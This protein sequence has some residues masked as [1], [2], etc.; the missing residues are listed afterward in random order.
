[1]CDPFVPRMS[2][3]GFAPFTLL[4]LSIHMPAMFSTT[5]AVTVTASASTNSS[6]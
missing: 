5:G 3:L 2:R 4:T 1:M 6:V